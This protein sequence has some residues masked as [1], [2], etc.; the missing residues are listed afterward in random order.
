MEYV[1][2]FKTEKLSYSHTVM[3]ENYSE[4]LELLGRNILLNSNRSTNVWHILKRMK[5][6]WLKY[7]G[8]TPQI[9]ISF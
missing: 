6:Y 5:W 3:K 7:M 4:N 1:L 8:K 2:A 9:D